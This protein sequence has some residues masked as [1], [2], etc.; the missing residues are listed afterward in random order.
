MSIIKYI[1]RMRYID[2]LLRR[3]TACTVITISKK[4]KLSRS[5]TL[6]YLRDMR[7]LGFPIHYSRKN[8][9]YYYRVP[10]KMTEHLFEKIKKN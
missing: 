10:G 8:K 5:S 6:E 9:C 1:E 7:T 4:I 3:K 2:S